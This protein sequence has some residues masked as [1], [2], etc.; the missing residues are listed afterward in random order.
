VSSGGYPPSGPPSG[1]Y[2]APP[3]GSGS[4][5]ALYAVLAGVLAVAVII[6]LVVAF[7]GGGG[8]DDDDTTTTREPTST[9][10]EQTTSS[11]DSTTSSGGTVT[12]LSPTEYEQVLFACGDGVMAE[13]DNLYRSTPVGGALEA[14]SMT[15]GK[16]DPAGDHRG[17]CETSFGAD[18]SGAPTTTTETTSANQSE[19]ISACTNGDMAACDSLYG[20]TGIDTAA[21]TWANA[22][23]GRDPGG[24]HAGDCEE[25]FG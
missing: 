25:Q 23:G 3:S 8:D 7:S 17:D 4:K 14:F 18:G 10:G 19:Y 21:D 12:T 22:C 20:I 9:S 5:G 2:G 6:G 24:E 13:C 16:R 1:G 15:C 11:L